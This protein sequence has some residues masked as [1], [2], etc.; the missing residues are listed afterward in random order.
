[1]NMKEETL[2]APSLDRLG[3]EAPTAQSCY[4]ASPNSTEVSNCC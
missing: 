2:G 3:I 4:P 1:V